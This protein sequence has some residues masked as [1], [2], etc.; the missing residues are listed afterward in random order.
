MTTRAPLLTLAA[1]TALCACETDPR[2]AG[3]GGADALA[4]ELALASPSHV[5]GEG[6]SVT[7]HATVTDRRGQARPDVAVTIGPDP[8]ARATKIDEAPQNA[9]FTLSGSGPITFVGCIADDPEVCDTIA[10][11]VDDGR[12]VLAVDAPTPGQ[13]IDDPAGVYVHGTAFDQSPTLEVFVDGA[14]VTLGEGGVF[15]TTLPPRFG[16][17]HVDVLATDALTETARVEMD[18]LYAAAF[19]PATDEDGAPAIALDDAVGLWLGQDF[20]DDGAPLEPAD[21]VVT[22]DVADVVELV[23]GHAD[24]G[25]L[26]PNPVVSTP[27]FALN[28][29]NATLGEPEVELQIESGAIDLF[30]RANALSLTTSGALVLDGDTFPLTGTVTGSV[31]AYARMGIAKPGP[32]ADPEITLSG[33]VIAIEDMNGDFVNAEVDAVFTLASALLRT[34]IEGFV[35]DALEGVLATSVPALLETV[36]SGI[37]TALAGLT[38]D[39]GADPLPPVSL[40]FDG[41]MSRIETA[42]RQHLLAPLSIAAGSGAPNLHP[43]SRGVARLTTS[44]AQT[45]FFDAGA[46][47]IGVQLGFLNGVLHVL[48]SSGLLDVDATPLIPDFAQSLVSDARLE[49]GLPPVLRPPRADEPFDLVLSIGQLELAMM[50]QGEPRRFGVTIEAGVDITVTDNVVALVVADT[51]SIYVWENA[52]LD[53][54]ELVTAELVETLLG[55]V[56]PDLRDAIVSGLAFELPIPPLPLG[57]IAPDLTGFTLSIG[58]TSA[59]LYPRGELLL[60]DVAFTGTVPAAG[61]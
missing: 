31:V 26:I 3:G 19:T 44:P 46:A 1:L 40:S 14:R 28:V 29:T 16:V 56:W 60:L 50:A 6:Y 43:G 21:P 45:N 53:G 10:L 42:Y 9:S 52:V 36:L 18:V 24:L 27:A 4:I 8:A 17:R 37:D 58:E 54:T 49:P 2:I 61:P 32:M 35:R 12:P 51:P 30:V 22:R 48:W 33:L 11:V 38:I 7:F 15:E 25:A 47:Q 41:R 39:L 13:E 55:M 57:G 20:F 59:R 34:T 5:Y 23:V